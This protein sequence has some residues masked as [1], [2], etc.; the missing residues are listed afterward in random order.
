MPASVNHQEKWWG[1][2]RKNRGSRSCIAQ[3]TWQKGKEKFCLGLK[4]K[5]DEKAN[6]GPSRRWWASWSVGSQREK[7]NWISQIWW[8][9]TDVKAVPV[10][11]GTYWLRDL[12]GVRV[13]FTFM[14]GSMTPKTCRVIWT[15]VA[16]MWFSLDLFSTKKKT[17]LCG[18]PIYACSN[19]IQACR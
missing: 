1:K 10:E 6:T 11:T 4:K 13:A 18:F 3:T 15:T 12:V 9:L 16:W 19:I 17:W 5:K 2:D 14:L 8:T 7:E